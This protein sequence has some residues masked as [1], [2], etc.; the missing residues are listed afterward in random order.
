MW[1]W[2]ILNN[3]FIGFVF[4]TAHEGCDSLKTCKQKYHHILDKCYNPNLNIR[5]N[6]RISKG[7]LQRSLIGKNN[8]KTLKH[9][10]ILNW[11]QQS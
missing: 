1:M 4:E 3:Y 2:N 9:F 6:N 5:W 10:S 8:V 11:P 7:S